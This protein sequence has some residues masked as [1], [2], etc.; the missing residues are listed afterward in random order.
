M[1]DTPDL[2]RIAAA[3]AANAEPQFVNPADDPNALAKA[4]AALAS[5]VREP[6]PEP[7]SD[8]LV[9]LPGGLVRGP[10]VI[11]TAEVR[12]LT[13][14]H[15]EALA[16]AARA[17]PG[18]VV[19]FLNTLLECGTVRFGAEDPS[20]TTSLLRDTLVGD[21]DALLI[22]IRRATYGDDIEL[23]DWQ[24]PECKNRA[25]L[26]IPLADIPVH[27]LAHP[28]KQITFDVPL[29]RGRT[30]E[31]R[32][33]NGADQT[34]VFAI[35]EQTVAERD[36]ILLGRCL[37]AIRDK[38]GTRHITTGTEGAIARKLALPDRH[39]VLRELTERQPGPKF[40]EVKFTHQDCAKE[41]GLALGLPDLFRDLNVA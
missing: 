22:G 2:A 9:Q 29:R 38:D 31:V 16:R 20:Q 25:D 28:D 33:A 40:N 6:E 24:C 3:A 1:A 34:A 19:H 10:N 5:T 11:K 18:S 12:E 36:S 8:T 37:L 41:V 13:G 21:R 15:E 23:E 32:L 4:S 35:G 27:K 39:A 14:E 30:A 17:Q 7:P 26:T